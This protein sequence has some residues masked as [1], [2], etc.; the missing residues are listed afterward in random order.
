MLCVLY[1]M[2]SSACVLYVLCLHAVCV[3]CILSHM[4]PITHLAALASRCLFYTR[5]MRIRRLFFHFLA[6]KA[7]PKCDA[8]GSSRC[9]TSSD[10]QQRACLAVSL[11][12][13]KQMINVREA[14]SRR[15]GD[16]VLNLKLRV[17]FHSG[18]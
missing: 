10:A 15:L 9:S 14:L 5:I 3:A 12:V 13:L 4:Y 11:R 6:K 16:E 2:E 1:V 7:K 17:G 8:H 18:P